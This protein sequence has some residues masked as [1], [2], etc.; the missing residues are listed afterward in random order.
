MPQQEAEVE[1]GSSLTT[2]MIGNRGI[3]RKPKLAVCLSSV[4]ERFH[5][6]LQEITILECYCVIRY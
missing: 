2:G 4:L 3:W 6:I 1:R 5:Q